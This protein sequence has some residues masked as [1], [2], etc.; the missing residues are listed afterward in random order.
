MYPKFSIVS[1][2]LIL[3]FSNCT[4]VNSQSTTVKTYVNYEQPLKSIVDSLG[5]SKTNITIEINKKEYVL[6]VLNKGKVIKSYPIVL[7]DNPVDDKKM[8][9]D[10]ST[11]EG[12]FHINSK[13]PHSSWKYF[14]WIN[15]PTAES[16]ER[17]NKRKASGEIPKSAKIGG[18]IGIHGT[19]EGGDYLIDQGINWTFGCI[20]LKRSDIADLYPYISKTTKIEILH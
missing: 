5:V 14:I 18:E 19:P 11:P 9:G 20:S 13:Y 12:T 16:K 3:L 7:G 8:Q 4:G 17:F 1:L 10:M 2:I 15:Y 6:S